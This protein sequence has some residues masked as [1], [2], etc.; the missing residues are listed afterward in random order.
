[1]GAGLVITP[2]VEDFIKPPT[3][4]G[5]TMTLGG[6]ASNLEIRGVVTVCWTLE[7][8][9]GLDI[10]IHTHKQTGFPSKRQDCSAL[11]NGYSRHRPPNAR[12]KPVSL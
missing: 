8:A 11:K 12:A 7:A 4:L 9:D 3:S 6:M 1:M 10:Q 2:D 5:T